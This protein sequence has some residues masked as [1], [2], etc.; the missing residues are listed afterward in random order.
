MQK[1][2]YPIS[3]LV[4]SPSAKKYVNQVL[5]SNRL[6][7]GP[8]TEKFEKEFAKIHNRK[9]AIV[10]NSGTSALQVALHALKETYEWEDGDEVL[11]PAVTFIA[12]SNVILENKLKPVF[13]DI[14]PDHFCI[15]PAQIEKKITSRTRAIMPVHLFGQSADMFPILKIAKKYNLKTIEDSCEAM[16]V[17]YKGQPVGSLGDI[18][19]Y[20]TYIAHIIT[21]GV[22]GIVTTNDVNLAT[23]MKSLMFHGRDNIY[24]KIEDD[25]TKDKLKLNSLIERRFQFI[26]TG[27]S[28]RLTEMES[29]LGYAELETKDEN[30]KRRIANGRAITKALSEFANFFQLPAPRKDAEHIY[31]LYPI[32][33]KD[34]RIDRDEF[35]LYLEENGVETRLFMPLLTQPIYKKIF[36][37]IEQEFPVAKRCVERGFLVGCH[38][39]TSLSD[40][41]YLRSLF[42]KY[43]SD[44]NIPISS[45]L[46]WENIISKE[47]NNQIAER[48]ALQERE[49]NQ[50]KN[51]IKKLKKKT[52]KTMIKRKLII[53]NDNNIAK[54]V[55]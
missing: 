16:F 29:A 44:I 23:M 6:S 32:I 35:L 26:H 47:S 41:R 3:N 10:S 48:L 1:R 17:K 27:Y 5:D 31:M 18:S 12:S 9:F 22:G 30:V 28:Y 39:Y 37:D 38:R 42:K 45:V 19:A 7:Y 15:D 11:V 13:V 46:K 34:E 43:L 53:K 20:S 14:E 55:N 8:F 50:L 54:H 21:T 33:I 4:I 40:I 2:K 52:S 49:L 24:L 51:K 25:D 36:G